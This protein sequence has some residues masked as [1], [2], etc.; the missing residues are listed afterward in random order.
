MAITKQ[1]RRKPSDATIH[2]QSDNRTLAALVG[3]AALIFAAPTA[4]A[5]AV[6]DFYTGKQLR[7]LVGYGAGG[8]YD[9]VAHLM[10]THLSKHVPGNPTVIVQNMDRCGLDEGREFL[11]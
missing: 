5:D 6:S 11:V 3:A 4:N 10:A 7:I 9:R 2:E 1:T 8:G